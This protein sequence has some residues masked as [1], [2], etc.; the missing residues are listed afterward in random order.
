MRTIAAACS[1]DLRYFIGPQYTLCWGHCLNWSHAQFADQLAATSPRSIW[2]VWNRNTPVTF[3][4]CRSHARVGLLDTFKP[5]W[6]IETFYCHINV[7]LYEGDSE[8]MHN[9]FPPAARER[10]SPS[11]WQ[12]WNSE[13]TG[14]NA[15]RGDLGLDASVALWSWTRVVRGRFARRKNKEL[16]FLFYRWSVWKELEF[17]C[18]KNGE[19][20]R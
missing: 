18:A 15:A 4:W 13:S 3:I 1:R 12:H 9:F 14:R 17:T 20:P 5:S 8:S 19:E 11:S 2:K 7:Y 10:K 16:R 6:R